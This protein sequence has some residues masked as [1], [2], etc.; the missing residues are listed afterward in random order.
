MV[1]L[2]P[3][4]TGGGS[5]GLNVKW[6]PKAC[7]FKHLVPQLV[8]L[9]WKVGNHSGSEPG[10]CESLGV[11]TNTEKRHGPQAIFKQTS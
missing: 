3:V 6:P 10:W 9:L 11:G 4:F 8:V 2:G 7:V 1:T 5:C